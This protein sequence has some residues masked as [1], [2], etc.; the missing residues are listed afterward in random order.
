MEVRR[1]SICGG[2]EYWD[3]NEWACYRCRMLYDGPTDGKFSMYPW[4]AQ[5][6]YLR[7]NHRR[8]WECG[9]VFIGLRE[10]GTVL[11]TSE[12]TG[13]VC[14]VLKWKNIASISASL[15]Y[16]A[17][18]KFD[19]TVVTTAP[20]KFWDVSGWRNIMGISVGPAHIVG[21]KYDGTVV[22]VGDNHLNHATFPAGRTL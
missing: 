11:C 20:K 12:N 4:K 19:G 13:D 5:E 17:G 3:G 9:G 14:D 10:D 18:V 16:A 1:C 7:Q 21:L 2:R 15:L 22:A 8:I 6:H